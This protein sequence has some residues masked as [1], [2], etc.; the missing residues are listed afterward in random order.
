MRK[1]V[2]KSNR[3]GSTRIIVGLIVMFFTL[4][5]AYLDFSETTSTMES[6]NHYTNMIDATSE[7]M[8][9][10]CPFSNM[11]ATGENRMVCNVTCDNVCSSTAIVW[12][13]RYAFLMPFGANKYDRM[14]SSENSSALLL[15]EERPPRQV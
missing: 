1:V 15:I 13:V 14:P 2:S 5:Q 10:D 12:V 8:V 6:H 4:S 11:H 7:A 3:F 9:V